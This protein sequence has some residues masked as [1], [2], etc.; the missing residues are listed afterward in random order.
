V[1]KEEVM[2]L[3]RWIR[4]IA[5]TFVT[6][7]VVLSYVQSSY[8]LLFTLFVG[9]NLLQSALTR[10]CLMEELLKKLGVKSAAAQPL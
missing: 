2:S 9:L 5:G 4:L 10:W 3:E 6:V 7:S 8:W 1:R